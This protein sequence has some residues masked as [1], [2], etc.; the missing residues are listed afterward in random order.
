MPQE[1][2]QFHDKFL[3]SIYEFRIPEKKQQQKIADLDY[4]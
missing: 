3:I 1:L 2:A 4:E